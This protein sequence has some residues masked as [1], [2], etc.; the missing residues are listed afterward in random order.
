MLYR[1]LCRGHRW[2]ARGRGGKGW[3]A[4]KTAAGACF[5]TRVARSADDR[6]RGATGQRARRKKASWSRAG[7]TARSI[8]REERP[9]VS[10]WEPPRGA[11][12]R[13]QR[14]NA[15]SN[16]DHLLGFQSASA[17]AKRRLLSDVTELRTTLSCGTQ[18]PPSF[19]TGSITP[20]APERTGPAGPSPGDT[21]YL[22]SRCMP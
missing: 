19:H 6:V 14:E 21:Y 16:E 7:S 15:R 1:Q 18:N 5:R 20:L 8:S 22:G 17:A 3:P 11:R 12:F 9:A 10:G 4:Q 2:P 13:F